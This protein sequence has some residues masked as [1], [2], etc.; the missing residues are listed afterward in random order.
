MTLEKKRSTTTETDSETGKKT[1]YIEKSYKN[2]LFNSVLRL[3]LIELNQKLIF[4]FTV[5]EN[6]NGL[7][8][9]MKINH[10]HLENPQSLGFDR[11]LKLQTILIK[12]S[13]KR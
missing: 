7:H 6:E 8:F 10:F 11:V 9:S 4:A 13:P 1:A 5:S 2:K 3:V 12:I